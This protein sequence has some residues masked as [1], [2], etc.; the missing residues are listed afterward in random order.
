MGQAAGG[1]P[2]G[3]YLTGKRAGLDVGGIAHGHVA[4]HTYEKIANPIRATP[5]AAV[6]P[7]G[8]LELRARSA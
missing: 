7:G 6:T 8:G 3:L 1:L 4:M 5:R 2:F